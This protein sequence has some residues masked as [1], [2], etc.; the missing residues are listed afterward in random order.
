V[1]L[2]SSAFHRFTWLLLAVAV[3]ASAVAALTIMHDRET[4]AHQAETQA[5]MFAAEVRDQI[6][7][8]SVFGRSLP[9]AQEPSRLAPVIQQ[10]SA[11]TERRLDRLDAVLRDPA[12]IAGLRARLHFIPRLAATTRS[13]AVFVQR[14]TAAGGGLAAEADVIA[15]DERA[16]A[17]RI[18]REAVFGSA[19]VLVI[20]LL[21]VGLILTR[22]QRLVLAATTRHGEEMR[23]QAH[24]DPLTGLANRRRLDDDLEALARRVSR[25]SPV[26]LLICDLDGFKAVN[27]TLGHEAGDRLLVGFASALRDAAG[28]DAHVYRLGGD[29][30]CVV[31]APGRDVAGAVIR[32]AAAPQGVAGVSGSMAAAVWPTEA[33]TARAA[34]RLADQRMYDVKSAAAHAAGAPAVAAA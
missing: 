27:D 2:L 31:S 29:E 12:R 7:D 11:L 18:G 1:S 3:G 19:T 9:P 4:N 13:H 15:A 30:F 17:T 26:Q 20:A 24:H 28:D 16:R 5:S 6:R 25:L 34:L 10:A 14:L 8:I 21:L 22:A 33:P 32:A 23:R